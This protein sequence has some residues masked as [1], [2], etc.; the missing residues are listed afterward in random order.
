MGNKKAWPSRPEFLSILAEDM[1]QN[2]RTFLEENGVDLEE[3][4]R[5][6]REIVKEARHNVE[7]FMRAFKR[8]DSNTN[9]FV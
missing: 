2:A 8:G 3:L 1:E 6:Y 4:D 5:D 7:Q 9:Y